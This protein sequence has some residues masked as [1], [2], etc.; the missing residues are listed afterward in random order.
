M[1]HRLQSTLMTEGL[2]EIPPSSLERFPYIAIEANFKLFPG[3]YCPWHWHDYFEFVVVVQGMVELVTQQHS[4]RVARGEGFF[5][6]AGVLHMIRTVDD[7]PARIHTQQFEGRLIGSADDVFQRSVR[8]IRNCGA[9]EACAFR[10]DG[11]RQAELIAHLEAAYVAA[12][13]AEDGGEL[14]ILFHLMGAWLAFHRWTKPLVDGAVQRA[15]VDASRIKRMLS[16]IHAH[17]AE[18]ILVSDIAAAANVSER[19]CHRC[20]RRILGV[21][22]SSYLAQRRV[23]TAAQL[24]LNTDRTISDISASCGFS[25]PSYFCKVFRGVMGVSPRALRRNGGGTGTE[26]QVSVDKSADSR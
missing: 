24:L 13:R 15:D 14:E 25:S 26:Q 18:P 8:P 7:A 16:Y 1:I 17:V 11:S 2:M 22:P 3:K 4:F 19:E 21:T 12:E 5:V 20:F 23:H 6:N 10:A 9:L